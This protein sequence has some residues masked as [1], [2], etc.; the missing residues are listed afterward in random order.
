MLTP[1]IID[2]VGSSTAIDRHRDAVL[3]VGDG[4]ADRDVFDAGQADDVAGGRLGDLDPLQAFEGEQLRDLRLLHPCHRACT[5]RPGSPTLTRAVED[6]AD[7]DAAE[8]VARV[9]VGDE[10]LQ[11]RVGVAAR[12]RHVS[13]MASNSGRRSSPAPSADGLDVPA[14]ALVY[15]TGNSSC[16]SVGV[17]IDEQVVDLVEHFLRRA[18]RAGRSC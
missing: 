3:D 17:E 7:R 12:R 9:E 5:P 2:T 16:S 13:T 15:S 14:R 4:F 6:A 8:V 1:K 10:H 11:R 18:R